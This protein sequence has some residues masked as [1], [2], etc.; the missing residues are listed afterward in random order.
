MCV[1]DW[2]MREIRKKEDFFFCIINYNFTHVCFINPRSLVT[3]ELS[4]I[5]QLSVSING[6]CS[7]NIRGVFCS[8]PS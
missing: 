2:Q 5:W 1:C 3:P 4:L 7:R 8:S 6:S